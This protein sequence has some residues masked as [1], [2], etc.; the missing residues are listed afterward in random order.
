[1][2]RGLAKAAAEAHAIVLT[3]GTDL[4]ATRECGKVII[5]II[6]VIMVVVA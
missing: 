1:M 5:I 2:S 4:G 3:G 6:V